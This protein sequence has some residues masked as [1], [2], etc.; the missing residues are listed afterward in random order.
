MGSRTLVLL[1]EESDNR[2]KSMLFEHG[3]FF[4]NGQRSLVLERDTIT[5]NLASGDPGPKTAS[6]S[7]LSVRD[8]LMNLAQSS[9]S[10]QFSVRSASLEILIKSIK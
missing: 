2:D 3:S 6:N 1:S 9:A 5:H 8:L 4:L 7:C 10:L